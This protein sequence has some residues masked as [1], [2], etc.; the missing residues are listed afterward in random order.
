MIAFPERYLFWDPLFTLKTT[1]HL[2]APSS[3]SSA[4]DRLSRG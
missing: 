2:S 4:S 1:Q 3:K